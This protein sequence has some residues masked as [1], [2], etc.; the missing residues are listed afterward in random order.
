MKQS[1]FIYLFIYSFIYLFI[2]LFITLFNVVTLKKLTVA[3]SQ[4]K[5]NE[6]F[7]KMRGTKAGK[8]KVDSSNKSQQK[9]LDYKKVFTFESSGL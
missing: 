2:H 8:L 3:T 7:D 5:C 4:F 9:K 1:L 6:S